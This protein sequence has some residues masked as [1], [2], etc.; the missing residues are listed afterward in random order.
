M[1]TSHLQKNNNHWFASFVPSWF[2]N[3]HRQIR[4]SDCQYRRP[5]SCNLHTRS[6]WISPSLQKEKWDVFT[7][8][9]R[10][11]PI[12]IKLTTLCW[13]LNVS[14]RSSWEFWH[15]SL[16]KSFYQSQL[17]ILLWVYVTRC[18]TVPPHHL[19][20]YRWCFWS[21]GHCGRGRRGSQSVR[22]VSSMPPSLLT[23]YQSWERL[24]MPP[25][26][27]TEKKRTFWGWFHNPV[28]HSSK[29]NYQPIIG[30]R[31]EAEVPVW[32]TNSG[33]RCGGEYLCLHGTDD[34]EV[35]SQTRSTIS[36]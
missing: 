4:W 11:T 29:Q 1:A 5:G 3:A 9:A 2:L 22:G 13:L 32:T 27:G 31:L 23:V 26:W 21:A 35:K 12:N 6:R 34:P 7:V 33:Q 15:S 28:C 36:R 25:N 18:S 20:D 19:C 8:V 17:T 16:M 24:G 14:F 30:T 10:A